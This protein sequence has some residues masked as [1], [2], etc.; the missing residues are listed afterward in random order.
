LYQHPYLLQDG[1]GFRRV[2]GNEFVYG[3]GGHGNSLKNL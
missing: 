3:V 1:L 2:V